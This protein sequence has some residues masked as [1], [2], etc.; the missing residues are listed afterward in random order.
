MLEGFRACDWL[1]LQQ[2]T[3]VTGEFVNDIFIYI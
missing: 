2:Q 3:A 1:L